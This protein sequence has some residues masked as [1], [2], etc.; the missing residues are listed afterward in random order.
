[1]PLVSVLKAVLSNLVW[2]FLGE[3]LLT[4]FAFSIL[5]RIA[6]ITDNSLDDELV[7][8]A[9]ARYNKKTS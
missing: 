9:E 3:K 8:E 6:K 4:K 5:K 1:M 2:S 7:A